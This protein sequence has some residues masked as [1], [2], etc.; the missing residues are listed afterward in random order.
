MPRRRPAAADAAAAS[1]AA[2]RCRWSCSPPGCGWPATWA[3]STP[4]ATDV[5]ARR[6]AF[7]DEL[8]TLV[9]RLHRSRA[10]ALGDLDPPGATRR[11]RPRPG[12]RAAAAP[13]AG[14][15]QWGPGRVVTDLDTILAPSVTRPAGP[16]TAAFF[17]LD[18]TIIEGYTAEYVY[19]DRL[20]RFDVGLGELSRSTLAA[21][22]MRF[23]GAGLDKLVNVG[24]RGPRRADG[25][26]AGRAR[27]APVPPGHRQ[28]RLPAGP[29]AGGSAPPGRAPGRPRHLGDAR[30]RP[31]RSPRTWTSTTV[32]CTRPKVEG[33][34]LTGEVDGD[35]LWGPGKARAIT[36]YAQREGVR[37]RRELRL[38]QRRRGR[39]VPQSRRPSAPAEPRA[40]P[41]RGRARARLADRAAGAA[42][43]RLR[44]RP[45]RA[46]RGAS[47]RL[48]ARRWRWGRGLGL[49]N[50]SRRT[51][52]NVG[53]GVG[54]DVA[55]ALGGVSLSISGEH[56]LW[57]HRPAVFMFNHQSSLDML[58]LGSLVRR[59]FTGIAKKD[60]AH[61]PRFV[62]DRLPRR[63]RLRRPVGHGEGERGAAARRRQAAARHL[64][65]H[66]PGRHPVA[67]AQARPVQE[68]R[69]PHRD[70]GGGADRAGGDPQRRRR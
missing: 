7:A 55:L 22:D 37:P 40:G 31:T 69:V 53:A 16:A 10:L 3:S 44:R 58:V 18:G 57:S 48:W 17:D 35:I 14:P 67:H 39:A 49:L 15:R 64:D 59:D 42:A 21:L 1:R 32:L 46:H 6:E 56:H 25:R 61:D 36:E 4:A 34:M 43:P 23:R 45:R 29:P 47:S 30:F 63:H 27:R 66:R 33:G 2:S 11:H 52:A 28:P 19:R 68:G 8:R 13:A 12:P 62:A 5:T 38:Q 60:L 54:S 26:R 41:G 24:L 50:R 20:R 51:A 9:R 70:A 65:R